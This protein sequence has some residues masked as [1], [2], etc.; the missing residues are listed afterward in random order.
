MNNT[1]NMNKTNYIPENY[2]KIWVV[3]FYEGEG[4]VS[5]VRYVMKNL[6]I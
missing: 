6:L 3:G 2:F 4:S 5:N 1:N